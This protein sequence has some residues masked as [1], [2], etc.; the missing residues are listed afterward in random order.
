[1]GGAKASQPSKRLRPLYWE[2]L[3]STASTLWAEPSPSTTFDM[4]DIDS[5]FNLDIAP[6]TA[7]EVRRSPA[8]KKE[9]PTTLLDMGRATKIGVQVA[10]IKISFPDIK[11]ALI[12]L[13][14]EIL[15]AELLVKIAEIQPTQEEISRL[16]DFDDLTKFAKPDQ[17]LGE[18]MV[19]PRLSQR[20]DC[21]I[22]RRGLGAGNRREPSSV[23]HSPECFSGAA[24]LIQVQTSASGHSIGWECAECVDLPWCRPRFQLSRRSSRE[25]KSARPD[26]DCPTLMHYLAR[27]LMRTDPS[28]VTFLDDLR[29]LQATTRQATLKELRKTVTEFSNKTKQIKSEIEQLKS[30]KGVAPNDQFVRVMEPFVAKFAPSVTALQSMADALDAELRSLMAYFGYVGERD[31]TGSNVVPE[32]RAFLR[33]HCLV[34]L[35]APEMRPRSP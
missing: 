17:F 20:L 32:T 15:S 35:I 21:M 16:K 6:T 27:V 4:N 2:K 7:S 1:M 24:S 28:L 8:Q 19:I 10:R 18:I 25:A 11:K 33:A 34:F 9:A 30:L 29:H 3:A 26:S 5:L 14:D 22:F 23:E 12:E 31:E 13:D